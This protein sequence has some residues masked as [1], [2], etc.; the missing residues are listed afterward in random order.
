VEKEESPIL[1]RKKTAVK[2]RNNKGKKKTNDEEDQSPPQGLERGNR[3]PKPRWGGHDLPPEKN[4]KKIKQTHREKDPIFIVK[5]GDRKRGENAR[6]DP[7][8]GVWGDPRF[9]LKD[10][11]GYNQEKKGTR[12]SL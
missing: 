3:S 10:T 8:V 5:G 12:E 6:D 7:E 1:G 4:S 2:I 9:Q 11:T